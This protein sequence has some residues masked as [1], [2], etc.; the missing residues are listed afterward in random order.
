MYGN[1]AEMREIEGKSCTFL[2]MLAYLETEHGRQQKIF[3][4]HNFS[5]PRIF[6]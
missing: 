4:G 5:W 1:S 3:G 6:N 2:F